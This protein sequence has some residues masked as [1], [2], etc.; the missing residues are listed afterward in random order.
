MLYSV[1]PPEDIL[2][3]LPTAPATSMALPLGGAAQLLVV[4][5]DGRG[6]TVVERLV[7]T[8]P[9]HYLDPALHPGAAWP[10]A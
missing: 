1:I 4:R 8:D 3:E 6:T 2:F 10:P 5:S 9:R 7:A